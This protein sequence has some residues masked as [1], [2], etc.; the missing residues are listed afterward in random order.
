ME[1]V[2]AACGGAGGTVVLLGDGGGAIRRECGRCGGT[3]RGPAP[4]PEIRPLPGR[5]AGTTPGAGFFE[6]TPGRRLFLGAAVTALGLLGELWRRAGRPGTRP[7]D[8]VLNPKSR[9]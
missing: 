2:C 5:A 3:G 9:R 7:A 1:S 6:L 4:A 8:E